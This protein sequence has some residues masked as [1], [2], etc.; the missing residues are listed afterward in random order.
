MQFDSNYGIIIDSKDTIQKSYV[1]A[2]LPTFSDANNVDSPAYVL[3]TI[4]A[5]FDSQIQQALQTLWNSLNPNTANG[6]G[7][8]ILASSI[9]N[10]TRRPLVPSS[11]VVTFTVN[12]SPGNNIPAVTSLTLPVGWSASASTLNPSPQ[13]STTQTYTYTANGTYS[14]IMYSNNIVTTVAATKLNLFDNLGGYVSGFSNPQSSLLGK[15]EETD[16]QLL[17]RRKYYLNIAGQTYYGIE[18]A[19]QGLNIAALRSQFV[20]ETIADGAAGTV[21]S[22]GATIYL[23]YPATGPNG[24]FDVNDLNV[25]AIANAI[26]EFHPFGTNTYAASGGVGATT[27]PVNTPYGSYT[28]SVILNPMQLQRVGVTLRFVYNANNYDAGFDG[29]VFPVNSLGS[30]RSNVLN[31]INIYFRSK[32]LPTDLVFTISELTAIIKSSFFGVIC[33]EPFTFSAY[34]PAVN[35]LTFLRR[36]IGYTFNLADADFTFTS[37]DKDSL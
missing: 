6:L 34:S 9:I 19:I 22:R 23:E 1:D 26:Y 24:T 3:A 21:G 29:Q 27:I 2:F 11:I 4:A 18:K 31:I 8:D 33:L 14:V 32:T 28:S 16:A 37:V 10:L 17:S 5:N 13:Y 30:L 20:S 15:P 7:L 36:P 35:G 12:L 25:K